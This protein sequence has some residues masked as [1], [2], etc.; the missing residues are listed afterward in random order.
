MASVTIVVEHPKIINRTTD[1][2]SGR[3]RLMLERVSLK[4]ATATKS[5]EG[6]EI[7]FVKLDSKK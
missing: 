2:E 4:H 7:A 6:G 3:T 1:P 5:A